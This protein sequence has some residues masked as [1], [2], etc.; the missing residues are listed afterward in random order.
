MGR[1]QLKYVVNGYYQ[2]ILKRNNDSK[3]IITVS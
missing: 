3:I 1:G 2:V